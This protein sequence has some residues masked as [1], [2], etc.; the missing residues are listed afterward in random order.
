MISHLTDQE[1]ADIVA[2]KNDLSEAAF[3]ELDS[4]LRPK[5]LKMAKH[6]SLHRHIEA[7]DMVQETLWKLWV[8]CTSSEVPRSPIS[9]CKTVMKNHLMDITKAMDS[10]VM[11]LDFEVEH[12]RTPL[13]DLFLND[14]LN[15]V[16]GV[17]GSLSE[18]TSSAW[19]AYASG[20]DGPEAARHIG[21]SESAYRKRL[22][23]AKSIIRSKIGPYRS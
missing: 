5:L 9:W 21:I 18:K 17:V 7:Q 20:L 16:S 19:D 22:H 10:K 8:Q 4:R 14:L 1:L 2:L 11:N 23:E 3:S 15:S 6:D 13:E 12:H